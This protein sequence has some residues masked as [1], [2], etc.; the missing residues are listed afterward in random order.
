MILVGD[1]W[2]VSYLGYLQNCLPSSSITPPGWSVARQWSLAAGN[3]PHYWSLHDDGG[4]GGAAAV[5]VAAGPKQARHAGARLAGRHASRA[6][7]RLDDADF[8]MLL[9]V[10]RRGD[11]YNACD[12]WGSKS[13]DSLS[14]SISRRQFVSKMKVQLGISFNFFFGK[15]AL[16]PFC[17]IAS[18]ETQAKGPGRW[19]LM[20]GN[21]LA[22]SGLSKA[23]VKSTR[24]ASVSHAWV[25]LLRRRTSNLPRPRTSCFGCSMRIRVAWAA[26][27]WELGHTI[28]KM[29]YSCWRLMREGAIDLAFPAAPQCPPGTSVFASS[30][31]RLRLSRVPSEIR[32]TDVMM[33]SPHCP[34]RPGR[35]R[36]F[37]LHND[38]AIVSWYHLSPP[39]SISD[40]KMAEMLRG[41]RAAAIGRPIIWIEWIRRYDI[42]WQRSLEQTSEILS[43]DK[44]YNPP[45][46]A[47]WNCLDVKYKKMGS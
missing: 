15:V 27:V 33:T 40:G 7:S 44:R 30:S 34:V 13:Y 21:A 45:K 29:C 24:P 10:E 38:I 8:P 1:M 20:M 16:Y 39:S 42:C 12:V 46:H 35:Q 11:G 14:M 28:H 37:L 47:S 19:L 31:Y 22:R 9:R 41:E 3:A 23:T 43:P 17:I 36:P 6:G 4:G 32:L 26:V 5:V 25:R 2:D 18:P